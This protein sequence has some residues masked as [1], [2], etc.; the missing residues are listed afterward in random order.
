MGEIVSREPENQCKTN[1]SNKQT[2]TEKKK[3]KTNS[4]SS[5]QNSPPTCCPSVSWFAQGSLLTGNTDLSSHG[6]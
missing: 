6:N 1:R 3:C 2:K 5:I 4:G